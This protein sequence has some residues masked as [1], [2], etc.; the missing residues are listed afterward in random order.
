[1]YVLYIFDAFYIIKIKSII[2]IIPIV[3]MFSILHDT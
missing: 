3:Q 2:G 1:M